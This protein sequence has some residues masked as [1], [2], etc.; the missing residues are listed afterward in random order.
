MAFGSDDVASLAL[1]LS[2]ERLGALNKLTGSAQTSIELHQQTLRLSASLMVVI[3]TIEIA[4]RNAVCENLA[5]HFG[6]ADWLQRPPLPFTWRTPE[7]QKI[8]AAHDS[9]KRAMYAKLSQ[10]DKASLDV[11]IQQTGHSR[12][13]S[14]VERVKAR[15]K[16]IQV[17][18]GQ[19]VAELTLFFWKRLY[20]PEYDHWLW[21]PT[22]KRTFPHRTITRAKVAGEL[23]KIYQARNRIAHHEPVLHRRFYET[24]SAVEFVVQNMM[25]AEPNVSTPLARLLSD[26]VR[27]VMLEAEHLHAR[28]DAFRLSAV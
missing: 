21:K 23:E 25:V 26:D 19:V 6:V 4:L 20:G 8:S 13:L 11:G 16:H 24:L 1:M 27:G 12:S 10:R 15:R 2:A 3:A 18:E 14:H 7:K 5:Q 22:L 28:L 17:S 9:A